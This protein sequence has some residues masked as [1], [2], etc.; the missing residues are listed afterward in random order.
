[1][2]DEFIS[3]L[4]SIKLPKE[5]KWMVN[6]CVAMI[7]EA[8]KPEPSKHTANLIVNRYYLQHYE[9]YFTNHYQNMPKKEREKYSKNQVIK[10]KVMNIN[11]KALNAKMRAVFKMYKE[12]EL[13][14]KSTDVIELKIDE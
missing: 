10:N 3:E 4:K 9:N 1:M 13:S 11:N 2:N 14:K 6:M 12:G 7:K 8:E 5:K